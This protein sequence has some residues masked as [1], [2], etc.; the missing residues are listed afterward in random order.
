MILSGANDNGHQR[1]AMVR[2]IMPELELGTMVEVSTLVVVSI[3]VVVSTLLVVSTLVVV[4]EMITAN[5]FLGND[6][7]IGENGGEMIG[8]WCTG[9]ELSIRIIFPVLMFIQTF[10]CIKF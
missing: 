5:C 9:R 7:G 2:F 3:M 1:T 6:A 8:P 10:D 4:T